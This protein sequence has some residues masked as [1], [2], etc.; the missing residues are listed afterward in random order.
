M[1]GPTV[2]FAAATDFI[3]TTARLLDR[4]RFA[5]HFLDA[6]RGP[7]VAALRAYQNPDGGFGSGLEPDIRARS[8]QTIPTWTALVL[9]DELDAFD[10]P[11]VRPALDFLQTVTTAQ[12][13]VPFALASVMD[14]PRAPWW[15]VPAD[16]P[17]SVNPT[18]AIAA[19]LY[20]NHVEHPWLE[21]AAAFC[22]QHIESIES[23]NP[24]DARAI[25]PFLEHVP[26]RDRA[27]RAFE[28]LS[29]MILDGGLVA[30]DPAPRE[31]AHY[32]L[33]YA[34]TPDTIARRMFSGEVMD[35]HL[36][37]FSTQ[38]EKDGGWP[39]NW[40]VWAPAVGLEWRGVV[41]VDALLT[42]RA[43]KRL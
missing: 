3:W 6:P 14:Y 28:R 41:T 18:A 34:P 26:Q 8:S 11:L 33:M 21:P 9:L 40:L 38:Q 30:L 43:D 27:E 2:N 1:P 37:A 23:T 25:L 32:P 31:E 42:L 24:Y 35:R 17:A 10:D 20:K 19:L 7:V 12:G 4:A 5:Y 22:W 36:D 29:K 16:P 15:N 39:I 13:G